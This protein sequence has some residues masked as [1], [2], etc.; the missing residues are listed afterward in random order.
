MWPMAA[1]VAT[2]VIVGRRFNPAFVGHLQSLSS[3]N[4]KKAKGK[5]ERR[6]DTG[7]GPFRADHG[8]AAS[9]WF[10]DQNFMVVSLYF[11]LRSRLV[12]FSFWVPNIWMGRQKLWA[13]DSD[14][15]LAHAQLCGHFYF[16]CYRS[17]NRW[18]G[19]ENDNPN[20]YAPHI[21]IEPL[22]WKPIVPWNYDTVKR[23]SEMEIK[24][25]G[26]RFICKIKLNPDR[27]TLQSIK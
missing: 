4:K 23:F 5:N 20:R 10:L 12:F 9:I 17:S 15:I 21:Q 11:S 2:P 6:N 14:K 13:I 1:A 22:S 7:R 3:E 24:R 25:L 27:M 18:N 16:F 19:V 8:P 26:M